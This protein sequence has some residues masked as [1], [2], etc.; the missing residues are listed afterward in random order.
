MDA[1]EGVQDSVEGV[2]DAVADVWMVNQFS[3]ESFYARSSRWQHRRL[4]GGSKAVEE[5]LIIAW[6][7]LEFTMLFWRL[8]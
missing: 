8:L 7:A 2:L 4:W 1:V 6:N 5:Q 3:L